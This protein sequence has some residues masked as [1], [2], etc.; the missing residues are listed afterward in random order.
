MTIK[1]KLIKAGIKVSNGKI[2]KADAEKAMLVLSNGPSRIEE[3]KAK[4]CV[5]DSDDI[6]KTYMPSSGFLIIYEPG[7]GGDPKYFV[8][9]ITDDGLA[10]IMAGNYDDEIELAGKEDKIKVY[11]EIM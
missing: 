10:A 11:K 4:Y 2:L 5:E 6:G 9:H 8:S 7:P 1:E 3:I